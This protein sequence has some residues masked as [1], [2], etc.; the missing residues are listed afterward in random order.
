MIPDIRKPYGDKIIR[1]LSDIKSLFADQKAVEEILA[2]DDPVIYEVYALP[3]PS[4]G[5]N[6]VIGTTILFPGRVGNEFYFTKGHF[7]ND[8]DAAE[9]IMGLEGKGL[10]LI[11]DRNG[12]F[13]SH[14]LTPFSHVYSPP[15]FGHRVVNVSDEN[16]VFLSICRA[17]VGHD[18]E[19]IM[20]D[21]FAMKVVAT[22]KNLYN[23]E[24]IE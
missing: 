4:D 9:S 6:L 10:A 24:L 2:K 19:T 18:Y 12:K 13:E 15:G 11:Q 17:D 8:P 23:Y 1:K 3:V 16:L 7:H 21:N 22:D 14:E 20:A 5:D